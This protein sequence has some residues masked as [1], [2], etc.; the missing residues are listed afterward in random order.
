MHGRGAQDNPNFDI[1]AVGQS[2]PVG[3]GTC[4]FCCQRWNT[5]LSMFIMVVFSQTNAAMSAPGDLSEGMMIGNDAEL[6]D[7]WYGW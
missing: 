6:N 5:Q 3:M 4:Y 2:Y 7:R 1:H